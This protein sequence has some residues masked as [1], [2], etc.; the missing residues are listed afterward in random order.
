MKSNRQPRPPGFDRFESFGRNVLT[1]KHCY[2]RCA[3]F[4]DIDGIKIFDEDDQ[5]AKR[6]SFYL[7][8]LQPGHLYQKF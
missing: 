8:V 6:C 2:F 5:V 7:I 3:R 1:V 4:P